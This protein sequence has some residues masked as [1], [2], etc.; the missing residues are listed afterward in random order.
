MAERG[1]RFSG[2]A[3][4][5]HVRCVELAGAT[6]SWT[7]S[8]LI[9]ER[10]SCH[11]QNVGLGRDSSFWRCCRG[12]AAPASDACAKSSVSVCV[13]LS[14][15]FLHFVGRK[16]GRTHQRERKGG[17]KSEGEHEHEEEEERQPGQ[18]SQ[19][20]RRR[21]R[22]DSRGGGGAS[23]QQKRGC[24]PCFSPSSGSPTKTHTHTRPLLVRPSPALSMTNKQNDTLHTF[25]NMMQ[26]FVARN[27]YK[28]E[29]GENLS[30]QD[31]ISSL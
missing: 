3:E 31:S 16:N 17:A 20:L 2:R 26:M 4:I 10:A 1:F 24:L 11:T 19:K 18:A 28:T 7:R 15:A 29:G 22:R 12:T 5:R 13:C 30:K 21:R 25:A 9:R 27:N 6:P 14:A 23:Q 8:G